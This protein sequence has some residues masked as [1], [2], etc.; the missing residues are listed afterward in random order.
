MESARALLLSGI[1]LLAI[2][3]L[4]GFV[5]ERY[6]H[7]PEKFAQWRVVHAGGS[8]GA[9]QL[10]AL[11]AVWEQFGHSGWT[12]ALA[13]GLIIASWAFFLGPLSRAIDQPLVARWINTL[14]AIVALP[15]YLLLPL[16]LV[17]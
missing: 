6:R 3:A 13:W 11:A 14:G 15:T 4:L 8:A 10:L 17:G 7:S 16:L 9:V 2:S 5:Q 12:T 1:P